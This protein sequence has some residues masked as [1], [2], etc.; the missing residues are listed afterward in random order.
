MATPRYFPDTGGTEMHVHEVGRRLAKSGINVTLLTTFPHK[1]AESIPEVEYVEGMKIVRVQAWTQPH[2]FYIAPAIRLFIKR[3]H[4][5]LIHCQGCHT[6]FPL[7]VMLAAKAEKIPY[8]ATF[9][10]GGHSSRL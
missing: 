2:D 10:S 5:Y 9:H 3:G 1:H 4:W 6:F 7:L 8:L